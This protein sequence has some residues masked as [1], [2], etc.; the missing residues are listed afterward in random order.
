MVVME[1]S[2]GNPPINPDEVVVSFLGD[3]YIADS[4]MLLGAHEIVKKHIVSHS[5][6]AEKYDD[7]SKY[8][9]MENGFETL[10]FDE[11][12]RKTLE[13]IYKQSKALTPS[14][15]TIPSDESKH[16]QDAIDYLQEW[17][18]EIYSKKTGNT[19]IKVICSRHMI[20]RVAG[21]DDKTCHIQGNPLIH[22]D[23]IDFDKT[24]KRQCEEQEKQPIPVACPP[25]EKL[26][27]VVNIWFPTEEIT[28][29]PL[30]FLEG[31][32]EIKDYVPIRL[33]VG[34][35]AASIRY[36]EGVK[37]V[38]KNQM[39]D[40]EV[41]IFRSATQSADKK[42]VLH[43][44]FRITDEAH[45]RKSVELRCLIFSDDLAAG[46]SRT[47][48]NRNLRKRRTRKQH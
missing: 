22:L 6:L 28:D 11:N 13:P 44:S 5:I 3:E 21:C 45:L 41:Y 42:G 14:N 19:R 17:M 9:F 8:T 7:I 25:I 33:V 18:K 36:K 26:I 2:P 34:S 15:Q 23:Y 12:S 27:D 48:K 37:V 10:R 38:Y 30:G 1:L 39:N 32:I 31:N 43:G 40:P 47:R 20:L 24:Y 29:W 4:L 35:Q 46:G 16:I